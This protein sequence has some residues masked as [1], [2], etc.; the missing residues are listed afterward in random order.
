[1]PLNCAISQ[2][3]LEQDLG[4]TNPGSQWGG[5]LTRQL[6][7]W[8]FAC[9][10]VSLIIYVGDTG[11]VA[12][13]NM[14]HNAANCW[15]LL[16]HQ[17]APAHLTRLLAVPRKAETFLRREAHSPWGPAVKIFVRVRA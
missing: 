11:M 6:V 7:I 8:H 17:K 3:H 9:G 2:C 13:S 10:A 12:A 1:M 14:R 15:I 16:T 5:E 4:F